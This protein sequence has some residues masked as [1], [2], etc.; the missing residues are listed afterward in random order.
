MIIII[1][2]GSCHQDIQRLVKH[3]FPYVEPIKNRIFHLPPYFSCPC[4]F[5][6]YDSYHHTWFF[7]SIK[8]TNSP[9]SVYIPFFLANILSISILH[10]MSLSE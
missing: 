2:N 8:Q 5:S 6:I 9:N 7:I 3:L 4:C 1:N 10:P